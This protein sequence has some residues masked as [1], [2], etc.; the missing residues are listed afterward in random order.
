MALL[1]LF[2]FGATLSATL[3]QTYYVE[4]APVAPFLCTITQP[5]RVTD[6]PSSF[7]T[8]ATIVFVG[9]TTGTSNLFNIGTHNFIHP[10][11]VISSGLIFNAS[12]LQTTAADSVTCNSSVFMG[13]SVFNA[14]TVA[15]V[16]I[17]YCNFTASTVTTV[18]VGD[19]DMNYCYVTGLTGTQQI[20]LGGQNV[21]A[22]SLT[23][24]NS[25]SS[26][27]LFEIQT[28]S[29]G[30]TF[31]VTGFTGTSLTTTGISSTIVIQSMNGWA[32][33][34]G[35][36]SSSFTNVTSASA[37]IEMKVLPFTGS[38]SFECTGT[39]VAFTIN[40]GSCANGIYYSNNQNPQNT[41]LTQIS[42]TQ[43]TGVNFQNGPAFLLHSASG[44]DIVDANDRVNNNICA[45]INQ[46]WLAT[47]T[48]V[49]AD[50]FFFFSG[51]D[52]A[53]L[54]THLCPHV[55]IN[56]GLVCQ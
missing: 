7:T 17:E 11:I 1:F 18:T 28:G 13:K 40:G 43:A 35:F 56:G 36:E 24:T 50:T 42:L 49:T 30:G 21:T 20:L 31:F 3:A 15:E 47:C 27:A 54:N 12:K 32:F 2:V 4:S 5:C 44:W 39:Y 33:S 48:G 45:P 41:A 23:M 29:D 34:S 8:A 26:N 52:N 14:I 55:L 37:F 6:L 19:L 53:T 16:Q 9:P 46:A 10:S 38:S 22:L 51:H 25:I